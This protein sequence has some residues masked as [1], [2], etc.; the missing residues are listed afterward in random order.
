VIELAEFVVALPASAR[1]PVSTRK[2]P[3]DVIEHAVQN[4][5]KVPGMTSLDE[6]VESRIVAESGVDR[7]RIDRV[8]PMSGGGVDRREED[9]A[10][11]EADDVIEVPGD[12]GQSTPDTVAVKVIEG[13]AGHP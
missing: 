10:T 1:Q 8:V 12:G 4:E 11:A 9:A 7:E 13:P 3:S 2:V 5:A 6:F